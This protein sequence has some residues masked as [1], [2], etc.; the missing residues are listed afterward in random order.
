MNSVAQTGMKNSRSDLDDREYLDQLAFTLSSRRSVFDNR[1]YAVASTLTELQ[2]QLHDSL[3]KARRATKNDKLFMI[4]TGQG[5]HWQRMGAEL[6]VYPVFARS[7]DSTQEYLRTLGCPWNLVEELLRKEDSRLH[8]PSLSQPICTAIQVALVDLLS[9]WGVRAKTVVGHSSGEIAAAYAAQIISHE[10]AVS[11]ANFRGVYSSLVDERLGNTTTGTMMAAGVSEKEAELYLTR[12]TSGRA[13]V[14]CI[15]SPLSVT[16]SGDG[17]AIS[18]LQTMLTVDGKFA[19]ALRVTTAYHSH[20]MLTIADDYLASMA[21]L[22]TLLPSKDAPVMF[23]S[24]TGARIQAIE[25][26]AAYWVKN[27]TSPVRFAQAVKSL[28][29]YSETKKRR[30]TVIKY[31][32]VLEV[33]PHAALQ[34]P[35]KQILAE[36]DDRL[37]NTILY[38]SVLSRGKQ[39]DRS[40][41]SCIGSMW[42]QGLTVDLARVNFLDQSTVLQSIVGPPSIPLESYQIILA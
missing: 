28:L 39:A 19:R 10:T 8:E 23:S 1:S 40:A 5:A 38:N 25:I 2:G 34:G 15:N 24:V 9:H 35:L 20:H 33:G 12:L 29:S 36:V 27:M 30:K 18:E 14:A 16:L 17:S 26:D 3:P 42:A 22:P 4:F 31:G 41:L 21:E 13:V 11:I 6:L 32:C 37:N 7:L